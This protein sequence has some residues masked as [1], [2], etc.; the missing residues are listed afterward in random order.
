MKKL[1]RDIKIE[2]CLKDYKEDEEIKVE[3]IQIINSFLILIKK[4]MKNQYLTLKITLEV[5]MYI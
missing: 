5:V 2:I 3:E 1:K 4:N